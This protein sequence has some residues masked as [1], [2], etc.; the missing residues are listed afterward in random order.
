M[1]LD[2]HWYSTIFGAYFFAGSVVAILSLLSI[3]LISL[4]KRGRL[5]SAVTAEHY[6]DIGKLLL[7][8][9]AFWGYIG[10]SQ[11]MLIWYANIPEETLW[12]AHRLE[13]GWKGVTIA[14]AV[15][16]FAIPFF[17]LLGTAAKR[18]KTPLYVASIWLLA[19]HYLDL[20]WL[21]MPVFRPEEGFHPHLLDLT[22]FLAVMGCFLAVVGLLLRKGN[23]I[24][25]SD[26]RLGESLAFENA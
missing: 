15:G 25:V 22:A 24:P 26:P 8:F 1:S 20:Y 4:Q 3:M 2:P 5:E 13:H 7:G 12:Y 10:F 9:T 6:H 11:F 19:M 23:L 21:V 18:N 17:Y 16:H 14:L